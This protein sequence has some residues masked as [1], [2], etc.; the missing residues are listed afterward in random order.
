MAK[1]VPCPKCEGEGTVVV[2]TE[3]AAHRPATA[4]CGECGGTG[5][6]LQSDKMSKKD[7]G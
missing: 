4:L 2:Q 6:K 1:Q 5:W 3:K 7:N